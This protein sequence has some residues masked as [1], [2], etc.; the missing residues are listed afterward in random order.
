MEFNE[1]SEDKAIVTMSVMIFKL[2]DD[3]CDGLLTMDGLI[4]LHVHLRKVEAKE[5]ESNEFSEEMFLLEP[6]TYHGLMHR[7][8]ILLQSLT[9]M[10]T[11]LLYTS[12]AAD[13]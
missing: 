2:F 6:C 9:P 4:K 1:L 8:I 13:E 10:S 12:D 3:H 11:C 7:V 5:N